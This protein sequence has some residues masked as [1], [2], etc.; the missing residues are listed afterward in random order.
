[1]KAKLLLVLIAFAVTSSGCA[2]FNQ[3]T[4][5]Y[6]I[7]KKDIAAMNKGVPYAPETDGFFVSDFYLGEVMDAK[8]E[9]A[10]RSA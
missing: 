8:V 2:T 5:I 4:P 3:K 7:E 1:M 9:Q 10:K 6:M